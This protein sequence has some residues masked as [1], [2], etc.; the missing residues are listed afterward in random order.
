VF[1][2]DEVESAQLRPAGP[3]LGG[4]HTRIPMP[5]NART[6]VWTVKAS[7]P[8]A[9]RWVRSASRLRISYRNG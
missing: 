8:R 5:L 3:A 4:Y 7:T 2:P 6:G 9:N 1:R